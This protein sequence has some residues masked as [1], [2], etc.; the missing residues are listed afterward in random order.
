VGRARKRARLA[1]QAE[2][3]PSAGGRGA[4][5]GRQNDVES[6]GRSS[7]VRQPPDPAAVERA[8][9]ADER[10]R[11]ERQR[12]L[13]DPEWRRA[14]RRRI[15][16]LNRL[17]DPFRSWG[18][19]SRW[20]GA[21]VTFLQLWLVVVV[22]LLLMKATTGVWLPQWA[23]VVALALAVGTQFACRAINLRADARA[24]QQSP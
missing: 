23:P 21:A 4:T 10:A 7:D 16:R 6:T 20:H 2:R 12:R 3:R 22:T 14:E 1:Q 15:A 18:D 9:D 5:P 8:R 24:E 17:P 13:Q 11:A 19:K